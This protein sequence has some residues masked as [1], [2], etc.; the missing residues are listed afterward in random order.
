MHCTVRQCVIPRAGNARTG[1]VKVIDAAGS[2][3][4]LLLAHILEDCLDLH[5][6]VRHGK[7]A[8]GDYKPCRRFDLPHLEV[9]ACIGHGGQD[10]L[11]TEHGFRMR[12]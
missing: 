10:D 2:K 3:G 6:A 5:I 7:P 8:V 4:E 11:S 12:G 9:V 1:E